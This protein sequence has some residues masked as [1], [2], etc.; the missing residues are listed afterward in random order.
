[1]HDKVDLYPSLKTW[2]TFY[3]DYLYPHGE[4]CEPFVRWRYHGV[5]WS[6]SWDH[7]HEVGQYDI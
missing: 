6:D 5:E 4:M 7:N 2:K 3:Q 1:M